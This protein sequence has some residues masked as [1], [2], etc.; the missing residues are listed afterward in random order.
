MVEVRGSPYTVNFSNNIET[1][2]NS[3]NPQSLLKLVQKW[4]KQIKNFIQDTTEGVRIQGKDLDDPK[5][6]IGVKDMVELV[7]NQA[8]AITLKF[9]QLDESIKLLEKITSKS[10]ELEKEAEKLF[11]EWNGLK[12]LAKDVKKEITHL[13]DNESKTLSNS[14]T[15][16]YKELSGFY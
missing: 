13:L 10:D 9:D 5:T 4:I 11:D 7:K 12:K 16:L 8:S 6:L 2:N 14:S 1:E 15:N 3:V